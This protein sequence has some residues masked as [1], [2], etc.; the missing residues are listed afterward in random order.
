MRPVGARLRD[1]CILHWPVEPDALERRLPPALSAARRAGHAWV[2]VLG[3]RTRPMVGPVPLPGAFGQVTTRTYVRANDVDAVHF[4]R[5]DADSPI[6]AAAARTLFGVPFVHA[7][8]SVAVDGDTVRIRT[9]TPDDRSLF[10]ATFDRPGATGPV[11]GDSLV[12]WLTDR[13]TFALADGRIGEV[14]HDPWTVADVDAEVRTT[15]LFDAADVPP[16]V[17]DPLCCYAHEARFALR[18]RPFHSPD[19]ERS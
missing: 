3:H 14:D 7:D 19:G 13:T 17:G 4:L 18:S 9:R 2:S 5:V 1:V 15:E 6:V 11:D 8:A 10:D 16:R 12:G